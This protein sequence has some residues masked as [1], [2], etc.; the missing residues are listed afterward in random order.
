[1]CY[2]IKNMLNRVQRFFAPP[3]F[4]EPEKTRIARLMNLTGW[5]G[6]TLVIVVI[7]SHAIQKRTFND[8]AISALTVSLITQLLMLFL[9][10]RGHV[11]F[12]S[13]FAI[14]I[15]WGTTLYQSWYGMGLY[16]VALLGHLSIIVLA[17]LL[18]GWRKGVLV[19]LSSLSVIWFFAYQEYRYG[20]TYTIIQPIL[21]ARDLTFVFI[22]TCTLLYY[23]LYSLE[24]SLRESQVEL[25]ERLRAEEKLQLQARYLTALHDTTLGLVNRLELN[26]LFELILNRTRDLLDTPHVGIDMVSEEDGML[27]QELGYGIFSE[28]N[29]A[30]T[31][32]NK[33]LIGKVWES[34]TVIFTDDYNSWA[35]RNPKVEDVGFKAVIGAPLKSGQKVMGVL[36]VVHL[37][38]EREFT[39]EQVL[40]LERLAALASVAIDNARLYQEAQTEILERK[41]IEAELRASDERFRKVFNNNKIAI[42]IVTLKEGIFLEANEAF[43]ELSNLKPETSLGRSVLE[44]NI[45]EGLEEREIFVKNLL[46]KGSLLNVEVE[47]PQ[48][49][50]PQRF[51][52]GYYELISIKEQACILCMFYDIT[53][54]RQIQNALKS[55]ESRMRAI[56]EAIPDMIFEIS[57]DGIFLDYVA[58]S[59][60]IP[61]AEPSEF[62]GKNISQFLPA[63]IVDKTLFLVNKAIVTKQL[64]TFE[65]ELLSEGKPHFFEARVSP[66]T[67][68]TAILMV[69]N[70]TERKAIESE[71]ETLIDELEN[72][73]AELERF[74]YT[75]SHDLKSPLITIR[76]FLGFLEQDV[77]NNNSVRLKNDIQ[78]ISEA[79]NKMQNLLSDLLNLSRV[80]RLMNESTPVAFN[81]LIQ[82]AL[83]IVQG[84]LQRHEIRVRVHQDM[85]AVFVDHQRVVEVLQNLIDNAAKFVVS[86]PN[87]LIEIGQ[88][89]FEN[90][91]PIFFIR[92][93]GIGIEEIHYE[94]IFGLFNKLDPAS[95]GTGVGLALV[96]RI[97]EVHGGR[98]WVQST[99][100]P[101]AE[102]ESGTTFYF[103]LP[104]KPSS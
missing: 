56:L 5:L 92:D 15:T 40:L 47:F 58:S 43:W 90:G 46:E 1:M 36:T 19:A 20:T 75:V 34:G 38:S 86:Q 81:K 42:S 26:P 55:A 28:F 95:E 73:N 32:K 14:I 104:I 84:R 51:T 102:A 61:V 72:K 25:K 49:H 66:V 31:P 7:L 17:S 18:L 83:E 70:I 45:W 53:G 69:R 3:I 6:S 48:Q 64:Q 44:F 41:L 62:M 96:K 30:L 52:L 78:R 85:T 23:L 63:L 59:E 101:K 87:P 98:I 67:D 97:I 89:G 33:G 79:T 99:T 94:R 39:A 4:E 65:Y 13:I 103:T 21:Y 8:P 29:G 54:Q 60:I 68:D 2:I 100:S 57:R 10:R 91:M 76:G 82:E 50:G 77:L 80:G 71:R 27:K 74:T 11:R 24:S 16:D 22:I 9:I 12:A 37:E 35:G 93:N 88:E